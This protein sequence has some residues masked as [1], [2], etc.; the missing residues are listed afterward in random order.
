MALS[1]VGLKMQ[2]AD[3]VPASVRF[4]VQDRFI[5]KRSRTRDHETENKMGLWEAK[6]G[7]DDPH[8][9]GP[10]MRQSVVGKQ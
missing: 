2:N 4:A 8:N 1:V 9:V 5:S 10:V 6:H 7:P 3:L